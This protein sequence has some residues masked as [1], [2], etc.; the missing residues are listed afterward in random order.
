[1]ATIVK[2]SFT[3]ARHQNKDAESAEC[4]AGTIS[5]LSSTPQ[6]QHN[7]K[8]RWLED[9]F[10]F[11]KVTFEVRTVLRECNVFWED[12][13]I[14]N[15]NTWITWGFLSNYEKNGLQIPSF[16]KQICH[17]GQN[18]H[19]CPWFF[20]FLGGG[21]VFRFPPFSQH[22]VL[23]IFFLAASALFLSGSNLREMKSWDIHE[24]DQVV[25]IVPQTN[26]TRIASD[27]WTPWKNHEHDSCYLQCFTDLKV[28]DLS[29]HTHKH[30]ISVIIV[31]IDT[32]QEYAFTTIINMC[33][34]NLWHR[35]VEVFAIVRVI[36]AF[37]NMA[38]LEKQVWNTLERSPWTMDVSYMKMLLTRFVEAPFG[39]FGSICAP[40]TL[41]PQP[42]H[43]SID[44]LLPLPHI[45]LQGAYLM[46]H[47]F[48]QW[49][50]C[51]SGDH[52][53]ERQKPMISVIPSRNNCFWLWMALARNALIQACGGISLLPRMSS[54]FFLCKRQ[55]GSGQPSAT[56]VKAPP[57]NYFFYSSTSSKSDRWLVFL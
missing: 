12:V 36:N 55:A 32:R 51:Q 7:P 10:P 40:T 6:N 54:I 29:R 34:A 1:M 24:T 53:I 21:E 50:Q 27:M 37:K 57:K 56:L 35:L 39:V 23:A 42:C 20:F 17:A 18:V 44:P 33:F 13:P 28:I 22:L 14:P 25:Q 52:L 45:K 26:S 8:K 5:N 2:S 16:Y 31:H 30:I 3:A 15:K 9:H 11:V 46:D 49:T 19:G 43:G 48:Y 47:N 38:T 41:M 4:I